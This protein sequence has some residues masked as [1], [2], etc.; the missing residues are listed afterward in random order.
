MRPITRH[1]AST[2][3]SACGSPAGG[4]EQVGGGLAEAARDRIAGDQRFDIAQVAATAQRAACIVDHEAVARMARIAV[5]AAQRT[6][7]HAQA[8]ADAGA[9]GG[10]GAVIESLERAPVALRLEPGH[11]VVLDA[12]LPEAPGQRRLD[13]GGHPLVGQTARRA[14][15]AA[16]DVGRGQLDHAVAQLE[17]S[18]RRHAH[19]VDRGRVDALLGA[20]LVDHPHDLHRHGVVV[21]GLGGRLAAAADQRRIAG[22]GKAHGDLG[23][24]DVNAGSH[25]GLSFLYRRRATSAAIMLSTTVLAIGNCQSRP[26]ARNSKSPGRRPKPKRRS[27]AVNPLMSTSARTTTISQRNMGA[28]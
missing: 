14:G 21:A 2:I 12:H 3:S 24:A 22:G 6:A 8:H 17:R 20:D 19:A 13:D 5:L 27:H 9:P 10:I 1:S 23:A 15:D 7:V 26:K 18:G 28:V 25:C 4:R 11:R 16:A